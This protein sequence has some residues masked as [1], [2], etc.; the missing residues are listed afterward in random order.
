MLKD[1][2]LSLSQNDRFR[3]FVLQNKIARSASRRFVAGEMLDEAYT[4]LWP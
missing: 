1:T 2:L 4:R 3:E